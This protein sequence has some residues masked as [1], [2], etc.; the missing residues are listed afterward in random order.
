MKTIIIGGGAAGLVAAIHAAENG[1][2]VTILEK[3]NK[4][5]KKIL[6]TGN[7]KCNLTNRDMSSHKFCGNREFVE[8]ILSLFD[9]NDT[10][11]FFRRLG[12]YT[13]EK[14]G[15]V[16]PMSNQAV[17]VLN[18]LREHALHLGVKIKTNNHI[19]KIEKRNSKFYVH[20]GIVLECDSLILATGGMAAPNTGSDGS[21]YEWAEKMG[22]HIVTP[23][24][25]LTALVC[26]KD[27]LNKASG[28]R[29]HAEV[30]VK[31]CTQKESGEVQITDYGI[32]GIPIFNIS[33]IVETGDVVLL[34]FM[35]ELSNEQLLD[36]FYEIKKNCPDFDVRAT[37]LGMFHEKMTR[38]LLEKANIDG[39]LKISTM[40]KEDFIK[41][42]ACIKEYMLVVEKRRGFEYAQVT[43]GGVCIDEICPET[44]E[45]ALVKNLFFAGEIIDVDG[46]C[47]GYNLQFAW[48]TGAIA[49]RNC[50]L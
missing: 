30:T 44:M 11:Q 36:R 45:S 39:S 34:D 17:T 33:R 48:A 7:G 24:P 9:V 37:L 23:K 13:Y 38:A 29:I 20:I 46:K 6:I 12:L 3:E 40:A 16:Y 4:P 47:G 19:D 22:H 42:T 21:G 49:G 27:A 28:V 41:L 31:G 1:C 2:E 50:S 26:K 32:S 8:T 35:P 5:G 43:Q 15:Y 10:I 18:T 25:A 14:K